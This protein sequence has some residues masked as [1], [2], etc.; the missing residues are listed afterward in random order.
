MTPEK[1]KER[2]NRTVRKITP[3]ISQQIILD[4][5]K[6]AYQ[7]PEKKSSF[8]SLKPA[9]VFAMSMLLLAVVVFN[10]PAANVAASTIVL[11]VNP[12]IEI[13]LDDS[14]K[15]IDVEGKNED[16][17]LVIGEASFDGLTLE[18]TLD[19][20]VKA[21]IDNGYLNDNANSIL[22][23]VD[24]EDMTSTVLDMMNKILTEKDFSGSVLCQNLKDDPK[25]KELA[26]KY[27]ISI[28]RAQLIS[29]IVAMDDS[30]KIEELAKLNV[31]QLNLLL[32]NTDSKANG[33]KK[34]GR[35]SQKEYIGEEKA[36]EIALASIGASVNEVTDYSVKIDYRHNN[37]VYI[38]EFVYNNTEY[39]V[40]V[41][42]KSGAI[43]ECEKENR[44]YKYQF[45]SDGSKNDNKNGSGN[46]G[47][48]DGTGAGNNNS[49][50]G[51]GSETGNK[52]AGSGTGK[53]KNAGTTIGKENAKRIALN[54]ANAAEYGNYN[55]EL[56]NRD[57]K[58]VYC[59]NFE[60]NGRNC[61]YVI[62]ADTGEILENE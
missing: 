48:C 49:G 10:R 18:E 62:D 8:F 4:A 57:G 40:M 56:C 27:S 44:E 36:Q 13:S 19:V 51:S 29:E 37:I 24:N 41:N 2:I 11:D 35:A 9:L 7:K 50:S 59:I 23:T 1:I 30:Y 52:N 43:L 17:I 16:A 38:T 39:V 12:S 47:E 22:V 58:L 33:V 31:H 45:G 32:G 55:S 42:G 28:G 14:G 53:G 54:H 6:K 26:Q 20:L 21:L 5:K 61:K 46:Q 15:V 25:L 34:M 3:D 60:A